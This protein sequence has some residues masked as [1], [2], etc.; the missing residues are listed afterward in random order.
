MGEKK[1]SSLFY[2]LAPA[3]HGAT[4]LSA[5]A[6][7]HPYILSLGNGNPMRGEEQICSCGENVSTFCPFW[8][9][10]AEILEA[11]EDDPIK[12]LLL[13]APYI[14]SRPKLN[15][16][17]NGALSLV[18]NEIGAFCWKAF[19]EQ[20]ER[21]YGQHDRF[22][23]FCQSW[24]P[25]KVFLDAER[26]NIKFMVMASMN[27]PV[28]GA[29][30]IVR[31]PR[32]YA[33]ALK[34]Y[35]PESTPE[36]MAM[37]WAAAHK[38]IRRLAGFFPRAPFLTLKYEDMMEDPINS[39]KKCIEFMGLKDF[40]MWDATQDQQK[41]HLLGLSGV[42]HTKGLTPIT[43]NWAEAMPREEQERVVRAAGPLF[44]EL[45]YKS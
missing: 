8:T 36:N 26:S 41:N 22:M 6:N 3:Y 19:Y 28:K 2:V 7:L 4:T 39:L 45:G 30:H 27:F 13:D 33:A 14:S 32:G 35:Y 16:F 17:V 5:R 37:E 42:D 24:A 23:S 9:K 1:E 25:H 44:A 31:D 12:K 10:A 43:E 29:I 34:K 40:E 21:F 11:S 38:R 20:A 18:A 15:K